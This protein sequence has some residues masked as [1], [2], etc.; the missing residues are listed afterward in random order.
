MRI[1]K[2]SPTEARR[3]A[4]WIAAI[5]P[6]RGLGYRAPALGRWLG[7]VARRGWVREAVQKDRG[8]E[9]VIG[10]M[11][12]QP[13]FLLGS[14][15]SLLAVRPEGQGRGAGRALVA[16]AARLDPGRRWLY[17][18]SDARNR[19]A[20]LFYGRLGFSRIGRLPG[21]IRDGRTEI[22][23]RRLKTPL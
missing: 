20:A 7:R 23:W 17:T 11:V 12:L 14:Y 5:D 2:A 15:I 22:L 18:S 19:G 4:D 13:E 9:Q 10:V 1:R 3:Q 8:V 6:W 21:L 16:A